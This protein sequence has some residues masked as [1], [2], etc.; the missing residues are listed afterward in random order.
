ERSS[1]SR[2]CLRPR[3]VR[4][5]GLHRGADRRLPRGPRAGRPALGDRRS[6]RDEARRG[7][8]PARHGCRRRRARRRRDGRRVPLG[9]RPPGAG[10][11]LH[12]RPLPPARRAA[13]RGVRRGRHGLRRP[14][15]RAGVRRPDV[16]GPPPDRRPHRRP[17][18]PR[19][20]L[21]L[22]PP[23]P[24]R[25]LHRPAAPR[26]RADHAAGRRAVRGLV[27]RWDLPLRAAPDVAGHAGQAGVRRPPPRRAATRRPLVAVRH[28][29]TAPR[30]GA[31]LLAA[32]AP[33]HRP[34]R[35]RAQ[36]RGAGVVRTEVPLLPLGRHQDPALRGGRRRGRR[37][38]RGSGPGEAGPRLP[39]RQGAAGLGARRVQA[40]EV[41]V[42]RGLRRR[43][44][45]ADGPHAG[46]RR[47]PGLHRDGQ[48]A[49]RV[50][51]VPRP[52]RP[53]RDAR[54]GHHRRRDGR[55]AAGAAAGGRH[56]VRG[57]L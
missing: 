6:Q 43:G 12:R 57:P 28:R 32:P 36:R 35:G 4:R 19:L 41:L 56:P 48:D 8:R 34:G 1:G 13:R 50:G 39:A 24:R 47:R 7:R 42:H 38:P 29:T 45:R 55:R 51:D 26:R 11:G 53:A 37:R 14:H 20:R 17:A 33:D 5:D 30:P 18:R 23:R 21:R 3:P 9:G 52:R 16:A 31:R 15:R 27:L 54:P 44:R 2:P 22:H 40:G 25:L 49:G 10:R 46:Q